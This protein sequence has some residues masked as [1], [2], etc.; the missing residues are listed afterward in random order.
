[1]SASSRRPTGAT[2]T[3]NGA[4]AQHKNE[5][6]RRRVQPNA[7]P[8]S[9]FRDWPNA[10]SDVFN[11]INSALDD[12]NES[13][14]KTENFVGVG[15]RTRRIQGS[16]VLVTRTAGTC[17]RSRWRVARITTDNIVERNHERAPP[18]YL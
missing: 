6:R 17:C 7:S 2:D 11:R 18:K 10:R 12:R 3:S 13:K 5:S 4:A 16:T 8:R 1:A 15:L 9:A 14:V